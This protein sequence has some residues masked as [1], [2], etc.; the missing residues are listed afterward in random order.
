MRKLMSA[1][2]IPENLSS[3]IIIAG[4][5]KKITILDMK[6]GKTITKLLGDNGFEKAD[7]NPNNL[8]Q[9]LALRSDGKLEVR[10]LTNLFNTVLINKDINIVRYSIFDP[11]VKD[12]ILVASDDGNALIRNINLSNEDILLKNHGSAVIK[13]ESLAKDPNIVMTLSEDNTVR[14]WNLSKTDAPISIIRSRMKEVKNVIFNPR[15]KNEVLISGIYN[16][17]GRVEIWNIESPERPENI[18]NLV[19]HQKQINSIQFNDNNQILTSSDDGSAKVWN[20]EIPPML[21]VDATSRG[22]DKGSLISVKLGESEY[23]EIT[24]VN[25]DGVIKYWGTDGKLMTTKKLPVV[26]GSLENLDW[27]PILSNKLLSI[28]QEGEVQLWDINKLNQVKV[29]IGSDKISIAKF[30]RKRS[31][32][33]FFITKNGSIAIRNIEEGSSEPV[34]TFSAYPARLSDF[35]EIDGGLVTASDDGVINVWKTLDGNQYEKS[36]LNKN[37]GNKQI[38][39]FLDVDAKSSKIIF[40]GNNRKL[41][42]HNLENGQTLAFAGS[43]STISSAR[44]DP[45]S[46]NRILAV[47]ERGLIQIWNIEYPQAPILIQPSTSSKFISMG[48]NYKR[49]DEIFTVDSKNIIRTYPIGGEELMNIAMLNISRCLVKDDINNYR[50]NDIENIREKILQIKQKKNFE[51]SGKKSSHECKK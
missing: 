18:R 24:T 49:K 26:S 29:N 17:S 39:Q 40:G 15:N 42:F 41:I 12:R 25:R 47:E 4:V 30:N 2:F 31:D 20:T 14:I 45:F 37:L 10:S 35:K 36:I 34:F 48:F 16:S 8:N 44:F 21:S 27:H 23:S 9:I 19:G 5:D 3:K 11:N 32:L 51:S 1:Q 22:E 13:I 6:N 33:G 46:S 50:L 43:S 38:I 7:L 28:N